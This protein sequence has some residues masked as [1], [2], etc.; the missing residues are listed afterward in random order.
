MFKVRH[1][2]PY[3]RTKSNFELEA[4]NLGKYPPNTVAIIVSDGKKSK[5][6][7]LNSNLKISEAINIVWEN[8]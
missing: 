1:Y 7:I 4:L 2:N 5:R 8:E 6:I 3:S